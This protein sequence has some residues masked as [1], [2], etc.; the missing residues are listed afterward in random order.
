M[1]WILLAACQEPFSVDRHDLVGLRVA[2]V[3]LPAVEVNTPFQPRL[4]VVV[5]GR[6]WFDDPPSFAWVW[7]DDPDALADWT[8]DDDVDAS[9]PTPTLSWPSDDATLGLI[10]RWG[11]D[12][13]R[14]FIQGR[15]QGVTPPPPP[16]PITAREIAL[17]LDDG[18]ALTLESRRSV[19]AG[20]EASNAQP[21]SFLRLEATGHDDG[22]LR[23]MATGGT[24]LELDER[25][26]DW[27]A[28]DFQL[29][30]DEVDAAQRSPEGPVTVVAL[31]VDDRLNRFATR[32]L[33]IGD[34]PE[35]AWI[36]ER[37]IPGP[38]LLEA[39]VVE[40]V[41][42]DEAPSG[43]GYRLPDDQPAAPDEPPECARM[44]F[45]PDQML[46]ARCPRSAWV[47]RRVRLDP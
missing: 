21:G 17:S 1:L 30:E 13:H 31:T 40:L 41:A 36:G 29:D 8:S 6:P 15:P 43:L 12:E 38:T 44:P 45:H 46:E 28:A 26:A 27:G 24:Y 5:D 18:A 7:L 23:W 34:M 11:D 10:T 39:T 42:D 2:A 32:D 25:S 35:G 14:A 3:E 22:A 9:G 20:D 47:G 4:A 33:L 37:F 16:G 19:S